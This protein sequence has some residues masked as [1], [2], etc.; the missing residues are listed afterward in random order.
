M[1]SL[2]GSSLFTFRNLPIR[3]R[4]TWRIF[5]FSQ[6]QKRCFPHASDLI[7]WIPFNKAALSANRPWGDVASTLLLTKSFRK[8]AANRWIVCPSGTIRTV[9]SNNE[10]CYRNLELQDL[11][12]CFQSVL[13]LH[14][15]STCAVNWQRLRLG[16][17]DE[18]RFCEFSNRCIHLL[19]SIDWFH[20]NI[21]NPEST[22]FWR[23]SHVWCC[24]GSDWSIHCR[25]SS[26]V[27]FLRQSDNYF[28]LCRNL[29]KRKFSHCPATSISSRR[30]LWKSAHPL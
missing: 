6:W 13:S 10:T 21:F 20:D 19:H 28:H 15:N 8:S 24:L 2:G 18:E 22:L 16:L 30:R 17:R 9:A 25:F 14:T 11:L 26:F 12:Q 27:G 4:W 5:P 7:I 1:V 29:T 3:P 23:K